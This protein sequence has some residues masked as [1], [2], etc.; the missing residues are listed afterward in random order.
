MDSYFRRVLECSR[1]FQNAFTGSSAGKESACNVGDPGSIPGS[2]RSP[3][4]EIGYSLQY[5][6]APLVAQMVKNLPAMR[7][8]WVGSL[9]WGDPLEEDMANPLQYSGL[10][11]PMDREAWGATVH[12]VQ[13]VRHDWVTKHAQDALASL[14][15]MIWI[16]PFEF[17]LFIF[18]NRV[19]R[20]VTRLSYREPEKN[21]PSEDEGGG[22]LVGL[23]QVQ[24]VTW[25]RTG[26][27]ISAGYPFA[28]SPDET[29]GFSSRICSTLIDSKCLEKS[30]EKVPEAE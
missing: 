5:S 10:E 15:I 2:G 27:S 14:L 28:K 29:T 17:S 25:T 8:T 26:A 6:R 9:G 19:Y 21:V 7:E 20:N 22:I 13:R 18:L 11:N 3:G 12:G 4:E 1:M 30:S 23:P 24:R 16:V